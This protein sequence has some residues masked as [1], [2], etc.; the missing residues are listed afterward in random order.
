[1]FRSSFSR[2]EDRAIDEEARE[3]LEFK[4]LFGRRDDLAK[5]LSYGE[6]QMLAIGRPLWPDR[7]YCSLTSRRWG[8]GRIVLMGKARDLL[9][10]DH[11]KK[12]Y[13]GG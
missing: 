5:G 8:L 4:G 10:N 1:M 11:V 9:C 7:P 12:A 2:D 13:L 3:L 6:R